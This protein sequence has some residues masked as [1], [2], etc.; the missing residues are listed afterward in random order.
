M[1]DKYTIISLMGDKVLTL[2]SNGLTREFEVSDLITMAMG[3]VEFIS[4]T[5]IQQGIFCKVAN[6][7][8]TTNK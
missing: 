2:D 3:G 5:A 7:I 6:E 4:E 8:F 1:K